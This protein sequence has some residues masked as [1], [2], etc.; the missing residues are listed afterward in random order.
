MVIDTILGAD[1]Y[2]DICK[3]QLQPTLP[4]TL[5]SIYLPFNCDEMQKWTWILTFG[6]VL[7]SS[8]EAN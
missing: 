1:E 5:S 2:A 6:Q 7:K 3:V 4:V 8:H